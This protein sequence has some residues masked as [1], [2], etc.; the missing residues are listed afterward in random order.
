MPKI[1]IKEEICKG[2]ALCVRLCPKKVIKIG[3]QLNAKGYHPAVYAGDGCIACR[4]CAMT[5]P[6]VAIEI[7]K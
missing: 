3:T 2:C 6:D 1:V 5:C 7:F 4:A